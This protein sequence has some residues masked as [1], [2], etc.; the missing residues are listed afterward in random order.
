[1]GPRRVLS[2]QLQAALWAR[3][4]GWPGCSSAGPDGSWSSWRRTTA[5]VPRTAPPTSAPW[6]SRVRPS[7]LLLAAYGRPRAAALEPAGQRRRQWR[8]CWPALSGWAEPGRWPGAPRQRTVSPAARRASLT[9]PDGQLAEVED[10]RGE[11]GVRAGLD[12]GREVA[13]RR[14]APPLAMTG[15]ETAARTAADQLEVEAVLGAVGVHRV[16]QDLARRRARPPARTTRRRRCRCAVRPPWVVTSKPPVGRPS[17]PAAP[18]V[19]RQHED[20]RPEPVGDLGDQLGAG[21]GGGVDPD[22]VGAGAQQ[23]VDVVDGAHSAADG[24]RDEDLLGGAAHHV[25]GRL[26]VAAARGDVEE[27]QLVGALAVVGLGQL[28]RVA[29]VAQVLE[30]DALDDPAGVDVE[31]GDDAG[32]DTHPR[33]LTV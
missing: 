12:G 28:D 14:P 6:C 11:H 31:A 33:S 32:G 2:D 9:S 17:S 26:P 30:V 8:P 15:T 5:G 4:A 1:M 3:F 7:E 25:V 24:Q 19:G 22:L 29:G 27:G 21:D 16:E 18:H 13:R 20:L 10:A 23:P